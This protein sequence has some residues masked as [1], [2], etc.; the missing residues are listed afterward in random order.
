[1]VPT[2]VLKLLGIGLLIAMHPIVQPPKRASEEVQDM[3][4]VKFCEL[5]N[6]SQMKNAPIL[7]TIDRSRLTGILVNYPRAHAPY[8]C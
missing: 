5:Q 1:M 4:F 3:N 7:L 6:R 2:P 8:L